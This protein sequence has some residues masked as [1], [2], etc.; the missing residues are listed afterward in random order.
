MGHEQSALVRARWWRRLEVL[1]FIVAIGVLVV[2]PAR[3]LWPAKTILTSAVA[4]NPE[5]KMLTRALATYTAYS[6]RNDPLA[7][8]RSSL[9]ADLKV[10]GF[11]GT[12]D[13]L[14]ISFWKPYGQRRVE[15]INIV[16]TPEQ[17]R[18]R[19]ITY[20]VVSQL[21]F[22]LAT[23]NYTHWLTTVRADVITNTVAT[24]SVNAGPQQ[25]DVIKFQTNAPAR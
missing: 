25:W 23:T 9:P 14:D 10:V 12:P 24:I 7:A 18:E 8:L 22:E 1:V 17:I 19:K 2:T 13:D 15:H 21:W 6:I 4:A 3:P 5:S 11:V 16:E 20:A